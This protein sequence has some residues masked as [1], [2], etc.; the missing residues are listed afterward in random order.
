MIKPYGLISVFLLEPMIEKA[1]LRF[2]VEPV[3]STFHYS[4]ARVVRPGNKAL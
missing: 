3:L 1:H 2:R 4:E